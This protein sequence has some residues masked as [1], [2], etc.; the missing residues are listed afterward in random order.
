MRCKH[1]RDRHPTCFLINLYMN[2]MKERGSWVIWNDE[3]YPKLV[4][5]QCFVSVKRSTWKTLKQNNY[6]SNVGS[7][8]R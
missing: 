5:V 1:P 8:C 2:E 6:V 3:Q 4:G 7:Q